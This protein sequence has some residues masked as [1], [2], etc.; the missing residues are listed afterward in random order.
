LVHF[1]NNESQKFVEVDFSTAIDVHSFEEALDVLRV[2]LNSKVVDCLSELV[3]I[4]S[5]STI[6]ISDLELS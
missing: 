2:E 3:K 4:K 1:A 5:A 6:V